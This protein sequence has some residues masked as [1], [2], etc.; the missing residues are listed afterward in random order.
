MIIASIWSEKF[1][2]KVSYGNTPDVVCEEPAKTKEVKLEGGDVD[3]Y[4]PRR[5][6]VA[7]YCADSEPQLSPIDVVS[8]EHL[9]KHD[10]PN[11]VIPRVGL[12]TEVQDYALTPTELW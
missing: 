4:G 2:L 12:K 6:F 7:L 8:D 5:V 1:R 9:E 10:S 11:R 3:P